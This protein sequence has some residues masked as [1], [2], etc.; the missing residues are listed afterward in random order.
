M[1]LDNVPSHLKHMSVHPGYAIA[2]NDCVSVNLQYNI[3]Q[4]DIV[5]YSEHVLTNSNTMREC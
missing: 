4:T 1:S 3:R 5:F 2:R